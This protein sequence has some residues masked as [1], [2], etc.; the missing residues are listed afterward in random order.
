[1]KHLNS[2][3]FVTALC[4]PIALQYGCN[5]EDDP[6]TTKKRDA[7]ITYSDSN[8]ISEED[9]EVASEAGATNTDGSPISDGTV[10]TEDATTNVDAPQKS[11]GP[12]A[13]PD[14]NK[15]D[16][17]VK[18]DQGVIRPS[19][20]KCS[21]PE[22]LTL[23]NGTVTK[24]AD[25]TGA[26]EEF[27]VPIQCGGTF[28]YGNPGPQLYYKVSLTVG[29]K[30]KATVTPIGGWSPSLYAFSEKTTCS[31]TGINNGCTNPYSVG[32]ETVR[33]CEGFGGVDPVV[34][35]APQA[36]DSSNVWIFVVDSSGAGIYECGKFTLTI[37][38]YNPPNNT[39]CSSPESLSVPTTDKE[40][41][42]GIALNYYQEK[43]RCSS[44]EAFNGP[45]LFYKVNLVQGNTYTIEVTPDGWDAVLY[46]FTDTTCQTD[47]IN[48]QCKDLT[49]KVSGKGEKETLTITPT[50]TADYIIVVS[51][52]KISYMGPF[53]ISITKQ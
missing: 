12:V 43:V 33:A 1:M 3:F 35:I 5:S 49:S 47:T 53:K 40:A 28:E 9:A 51:G 48:T 30:Y 7:R 21:K 42:T 25:L 26:K 38:E 29:K 50:T 6:Q 37:S 2:V 41:D 24:T 32:P 19:N 11:D 10:T 27:S 39:Q 17:L 15:P 16:Q 45:N 52:Q 22:E 13:K 46:A 34:R 31:T 18:K 8:S 44:Y 4:L 36:S 23:V 14:V 20:D